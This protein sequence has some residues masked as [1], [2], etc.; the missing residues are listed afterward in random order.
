MPT[1]ATNGGPFTNSGSGALTLSVTP[2]T[3]GD[4]LV[5]AFQAGAT[6]LSSSVS[7]GGV[8]TWS[9]ATGYLDTTNQQLVEIWWG[10]VTATGAA[11]ITVTNSSAT[12]FNRLEAREFSSSPSGTWSVTTANPSSATSGSSPT[13]TGTAVSYPSLTGSGLCVDHADSVFGGMTG[14]STTGFTYDN[15]NSHQE[16]AWNLAATNPA[17]TSTQTNT[18]AYEAVSALFNTAAAGG[19]PGT[20]QPR[21]TVPVPRRRPARALW[22]QITGQAFVQVPA[23]A[24]EFRLAPRR[25]PARAVWRG[26]APFAGFTAVPAPRQPPVTVFR[27]VLARGQWRG[28]AGQSFVFVPAPGQQYRTAPRRALARAVWR[29]GAGQAFVAAPAPRQLPVFPRRKPARAVVQFRPVTTVNASVVPVVPHGQIFPAP[30][31]KPHLKKLI[32][33]L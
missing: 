18:G 15:N 16:I 1:Y 33:L 12:G 5:L 23:P 17:P 14:G 10:P 3:T 4:I 2:V 21:A 31:D 7:G 28:G 9:N 6:A 20:V 26:S 32:Y 24:Q 27:R 8:T 19:T 25:V 13:G 29:G 22:A 30:D 11:T